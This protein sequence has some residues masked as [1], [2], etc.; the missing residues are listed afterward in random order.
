MLLKVLAVPRPLLEEQENMVDVLV[1]VPVDKSLQPI[2]TY[3]SCKF[4]LLIK[5]HLYKSLIIE[6]QE[7]MVANNEL[8]AIP[9]DKSHYSTKIYW[10]C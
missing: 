8:A 3:W 2:E 9:V 1:A 5:N 6:E 4:F 10:S 7:N